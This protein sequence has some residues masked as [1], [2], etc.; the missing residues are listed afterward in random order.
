EALISVGLDLPFPLKMNR[1]LGFDS[2]YV[3]YEGLIKK[4]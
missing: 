2:T 1:L 3:T 4:L